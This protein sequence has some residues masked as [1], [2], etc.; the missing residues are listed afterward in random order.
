MRTARAVDELRLALAPARRAGQRIGL[1]PTMGALHD[2]HLS[3]IGRAR[4][5]CD[6]VVVS[7]FVNPSQFDELADLERY[8]RSER[9]DAELAAAAGA[10]ILFA[11]AVEEVYPSGFATAVEVIGLSDRLEGTV[12]GAEHFRG[13]CTV[14]AKLLGMAQPDVAYFGQKDAQQLAVIRRMAVDLNLPVRIQSC[15][16]VREPDGL[17]MSSRN[18]RLS[19]EQRERALALSQ[20]LQA[21]A[22]GAADGE[23]D[24]EA[25]IASARETLLAHGV[26]PEY[27]ELVDPETFVASE[28]LQREALLVLAARV[29]ETRLI[30][31]ALLRA[32]SPTPPSPTPSQPHPRKAIA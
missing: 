5:E 9:R 1:V 31:N 3:L 14:V 19:A 13:V 28:Q 26:E 6:V 32:S 17:A 25:L 2:G 8:P 15:P 20:A 23:R 7:L 22:R 24:A 18:A 12:R 10:D 29:G 27:V 11:P 21:A 16:T 30:D 4:G